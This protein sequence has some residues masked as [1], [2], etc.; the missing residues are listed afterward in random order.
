MTNPTNNRREEL[1]KAAEKARPIVER[2][3]PDNENCKKCGMGRNKIL[4]ENKNCLRNTE[5]DFGDHGISF[6]SNYEQDHSHTHCFNQ[7]NPPCGIK[8]TH[9]CCLCEKAV[10]NNEPQ[11][12]RERFREIGSGSVRFIATRQEVLDFISQELSTLKQR[13]KDEVNKL[14]KDTHPTEDGV[15]VETYGYEEEYNQALSDIIN[16]DLLNE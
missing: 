6:Q 13:I 15:P 16:L 5:H 10:P 3:F 4:Q 11:D 14:M 8:G 1:K 2:M 12:W 9:R 7:E